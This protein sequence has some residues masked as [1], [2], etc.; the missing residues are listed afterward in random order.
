M[1]TALGLTAALLASAMA[2]P[3]ALAGAIAPDSPHSPNAEDMQAA[4]WVMLVVAVVTVVAVN[5]TLVLLVRRFRARR[6]AEPAPIA[7]GR[8][9][10]IRVGAFA[11]SLA[12]F[13]IVVGAVFSASALQVEASGERGLNAA[14]STRAQ[15]GLS[16]PEGDSKPLR[17]KVTGQQWLWRFGYPNESAGRTFNETF[18]YRDLVVPVD[19]T[20]I[21]DI[22]STDVVHTWW[23]PQLGPQV[24]AV[25]GRTTQTW[26][27]A[28]EVGAYEGRSATLSGPAYPTM[29]ATVRAVEPEQY[30]AYVSRK[31]QEIRDAQGAVQEAIEGEGEEEPVPQQEEQ[32]E[33]RN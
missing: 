9:L 5:A 4:Y 8:G 6:D 7:P 22:T 15:S 28:D 31:R 3:A 27:K 25:P 10:Q 19:T 18:S 2:A 1:R 16:L 23:I 11:T 17:I 24:D 14:L 21:L 32:P 26:F 20:V 29:R 33:A 13:T 12:V 30:E